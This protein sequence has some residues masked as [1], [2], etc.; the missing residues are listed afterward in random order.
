MGGMWKISDKFYAN[1]VENSGEPTSGTFSL[2]KTGFISW[3]FSR[4]IEF[5]LLEINVEI[6]YAN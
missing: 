1:N 6:V 4:F 5:N 2:L 3:F